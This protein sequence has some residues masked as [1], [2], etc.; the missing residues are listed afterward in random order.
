MT[1]PGG[2]P[3]ESSNT[4]GRR[5]KLLVVST[6]TK[7]KRTRHLWLEMGRLAEVRHEVLEQG[8]FAKLKD[9]ADRC[10]LSGYE[11]VIVDHNLRRMGADY[12][13][14]RRIPNLVLFDFDFY[15]NYLPGSECLGK[16]ESI[17]KTLN[18]HRIIVSSSSIKDDLQAKGF[19]AAY[20]PKAYDAFFVEDLGKLRDIELGFIGRSKHWIYELR[21]EMLERLQ[22][23]PGLQ[24][25]RTEENA[26]YNQTLNRIQIFVSPDLGY[27][28]IMIKDFEAMAAGCLLI[29]PRPASE[30]LTRLGWVDFENI[31][32]YE[33]Y[34]ELV[35][36]IRRL[37]A[38]PGQ[39]RRIAD[40]GKTLTTTR[41]RW[42]ARAPALLEMLLP[43][44]RRPPALAWKDRWN[45]LTL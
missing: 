1:P 17:L 41:H 40:A 27:H 11:R 10:D 29:A 23:E 34:D 35:S 14:L 31:V 28:E 5:A 12:K 8:S 44:L 42:E 3:L 7:L 39:I 33:T 19:D 36:K 4:N 9:L 45:L 21:R 32:L 37:R 30:E 26:E 16:L 25:L 43:P 2:T 13:Q 18:E 15:T 6:P 24:V 22:A 20:S 38:E